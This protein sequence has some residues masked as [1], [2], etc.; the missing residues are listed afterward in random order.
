MLKPGQIA[1]CRSDVDRLVLWSS[2]DCDVDDVNDVVEGKE[3]FVIVDAIEKIHTSDPLTE[4]WEKGAYKILSPRG[5]CG[6]VGAGWIVG[7]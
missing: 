6:W 4:E 3:L 7:V 1:A 5:I 2:Y